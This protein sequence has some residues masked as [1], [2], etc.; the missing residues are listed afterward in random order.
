MLPERPQFSERDAC[1]APSMLRACSEHARSITCIALRELG[2][3]RER[4]ENSERSGIAPRTL[5]EHPGASGDSGS[6]PE[7]PGALPEIPGALREHPG[8]ATPHFAQG[9]G[10]LFANQLANLNVFL[11]F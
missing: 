6:A 4:S 1:N 10:M 9:F 3:L 5:G 7:I 2:A 8:G 11:R